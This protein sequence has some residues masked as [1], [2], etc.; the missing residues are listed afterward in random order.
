MPGHHG[1]VVRPIMP[2]ILYACD[3][4]GRRGSREEEDTVKKPKKKS[5]T[6]PTLHAGWGDCA[7]QHRNREPNL[8]TQ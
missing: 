3:L 4:E 1:M 6:L 2:P 7:L 8:S 5:Q